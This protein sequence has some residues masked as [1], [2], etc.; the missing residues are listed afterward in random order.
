MPLLEAFTNS[1]EA[2]RYKLITREIEAPERQPQVSPTIPNS[3]D[4]VGTGDFAMLTPSVINSP[5]NEGEEFIFELDYDDQDVDIVLGNFGEQRTPEVFQVSI[6]QVD[7]NRNT[8]RAA[9]G[10]NIS[11]NGNDLRPIDG[12][13]RMEFTVSENNLENVLNIVRESDRTVT[14]IRSRWCT[15]RRSKRQIIS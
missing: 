15:I 7:A 11:I 14:A 10:N 12:F 13:A 9:Q 3:V 5:G 6:S 8:L 4:L 1:T 2:L